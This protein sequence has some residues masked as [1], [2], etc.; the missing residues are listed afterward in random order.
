MNQPID[1][2]FREVVPPAPPPELR[3]RTLQ[4]AKKAVRGDRRH[5]IWSLAWSSSIIRLGWACS[6]AALIFGHIVIGSKVQS[7][8]GSTL[9][10]V[11]TTMVSDTE[12]AEVFDCERITIELPGWEIEVLRND[13]DETQKENE[14]QP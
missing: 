4:A 6:V 9:G 2:A 11:L 5:D 3:L 14:V 13:A 1:S 10:P 12:L 7:T 8:S